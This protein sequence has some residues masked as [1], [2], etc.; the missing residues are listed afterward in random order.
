MKLEIVNDYNTKIC[1][2]C[3]NKKLITKQTKHYQTTIIHNFTIYDLLTYN[4]LNEFTTSAFDSLEILIHVRKG[5][6]GYRIIVGNLFT[7]T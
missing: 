2:C 3:G 7:T 1:K 5:G 6:N 4:V